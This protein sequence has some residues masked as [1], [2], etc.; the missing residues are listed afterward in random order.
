[1]PT[2]RLV[3][4][5]GYTV[6]GAVHVNVPAARQ[7]EVTSQLLRDDAP[8]HAAEWADFGYDARAYQVVTDPAT[9]HDGL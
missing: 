4:P 3:D 6:P 9:A 2:L 1:M 8:A 7:A 5:D